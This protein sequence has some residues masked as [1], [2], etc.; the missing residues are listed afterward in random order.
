M[1]TS[2]LSVDSTAK[3]MKGTMSN[4]QNTVTN[5]ETATH[6]QYIDISIHESIL[7]T[8]IKPYVFQVLVAGP[9]VVSLYTDTSCS[10]EVGQITNPGNGACSN[11]NVGTVM[12]V[13]SFTCNPDNTSTATTI[14]QS[15]VIS[16]PVTTI[17][18]IEPSSTT[19][20]TAGSTSTAKSSAS[21][22]KKFLH[23]IQTGA[24]LGL[25]AAGNLLVL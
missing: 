16:N 21:S 20:S 17:F 15:P 25:A 19:S 11:V 5:L 18:V 6:S 3:E 8:D 23:W 4:A 13:Q 7:L 10:S 14:V 2:W 22:N 12:N 1:P 24:L 9:I